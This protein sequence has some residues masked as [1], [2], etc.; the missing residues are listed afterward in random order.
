MKFPALFLITGSLLHADISVST[1]LGV[2]ERLL[3]G[4]VS[5]GA[6]PTGDV[7]QVQFR[8]RNTGDTGL[9]IQS[10]KV[11]GEGFRLYQDPPIPFSLLN[12]FSVDFYVQFASNQAIGDARATLAIGTLEGNSPKSYVVTLT[13]SAIGSPSVSVVEADGTESRRLAGQATP[14]LPAERGGPP[15]ALVFTI[16]NPGTSALTTNLTVTGDS[17]QLASIVPVPLTLSGGQSFAITIRFEPI[18]VGLQRGE[19]RLDSR[20]FP[21]EG[22]GRAAPPPR[23]SIAVPTNAGESAKQVRI[24]I[25][26]DT[27]SRS[28]QRGSLKLEFQPQM[29][30][31]EDAAVA[32]LPNMSRLVEFNLKAAESTATFA[33]Q[34]EIVLQTGTTAGTLLLIAEVGGFR[35]E[36]KITIAPAPAVLETLI[37]RKLTDLLE[38]TIAGFDNTRSL[39][40][41]TFTFYDIAGAVVD[42]G[43]IRSSVASAFETY[44]RT[45]PAGGMFSLR[46]VFPITGKSQSISYVEIEAR[47]SVGIS[48]TQRTQ[49]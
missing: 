38:M 19:L 16:R 17:F 13:A 49:F 15:S 31:P 34:K 22:I 42:P 10:L 47:N 33:G 44:F 14:F 45:A 30:G 24:A 48:R 2:E 36:S 21:L 39:T 43:P 46:A 3:A 32:F 26:F 11:V 29:A 37:G 12:R 18:A 27:P 35:T 9:V 28:D 8:I 7:L 4:I 25:T 1:V 20:V 41:L 5:L 23:P 6:V 40:E